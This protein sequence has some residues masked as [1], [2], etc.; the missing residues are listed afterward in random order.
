MDTITIDGG[1]EVDWSRYVTHVQC[2][3]NH[4]VKIGDARAVESNAGIT[5]YCTNHDPKL[6]RNAIHAN[7]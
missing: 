6:A 1:S 3:G 4:W 5:F 2:E 7:A